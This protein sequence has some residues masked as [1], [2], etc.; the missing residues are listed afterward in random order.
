[1]RVTGILLDIEQYSGTFK[2]DDGK[3]VAYAGERLHVL[4]GREV[5]K[6]KVGKEL[7]GRTGYGQG[8]EVD[9]KVTV[10]AQS[11]GRGPYLTTT[12]LGDYVAAVEPLAVASSF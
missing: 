5:V 11:G 1:M 10:Q 3:E 7:V 9:L 2:G 12:L 8:E 6:V 4:D